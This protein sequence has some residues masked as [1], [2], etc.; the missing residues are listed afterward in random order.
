MKGNDGIIEACSDWGK[1]S[2]ERGTERSTE[3]CLLKWKIMPWCRGGLVLSTGRSDYIYAGT[4]V[5]LNTLLFTLH[6]PPTSIY[7]YPPHP[8]ASLFVPLLRS[9]FLSSPRVQSR[10]KWLFAVQ[11]RQH[12]CVCSCL[13][14]TACLTQKKKKKENAAFLYSLYKPH[15]KTQKPY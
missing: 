15:G 10:Y 9:F 7:L 11:L 1:R 13:S 2:K 14:L 4:E 8:P 5:L 12:V 3:W 6:L